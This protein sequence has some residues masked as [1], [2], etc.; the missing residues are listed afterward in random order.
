MTK[1]YTDKLKDKVVIVT[2]ASSGIGEAAAKLFGLHGAK[3]VL[4][5][6]RLDRLELIAK[7]IDSTGSSVLVVA[8]DITKLADIQNLVDRT[9]SRFGRIDILINNAG[10]GRLDWLENLDPVKDIQA[11][12]AVNV[13]GVIQM[14][15]QVLPVMQSQKSGHIINMASMAGFV[16]M[17]TYSIYASTKFAIRGFSEALRR[18]VKPWGIHVSVILPGGVAT[19]FASHTDINRKTNLTTPTAILLTAEEVADAVVRT[20]VRPKRLVFLPWFYR[21]TAWLNFMFPAVVDWLTIR[22]FTIPERKDDLI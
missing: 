2:G 11:Q 20:V 5:A 19:E 8:A 6:R 7:E 15:R 9:I 4:A 16:A 14:T 3:V 12:H 22:F 1:I 18:E 21:L 13:I 17:P 10:F